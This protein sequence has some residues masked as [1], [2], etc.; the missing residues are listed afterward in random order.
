MVNKSLNGVLQHIRKL[1]AVQ[2][3]RELADHELLQRFVAGKDEAAFTVLVQRHGPMIMGVCRRMLSSAHDAEDACQAS[4]LVL[5]QKAASIRKTT[6]LSSWL[7]GVASRVAANLKRER[8]RRYKRE[9]DSQ[10]RA[11]PDPAAEI[12]WREV[13]AILDEELQRLPERSRAPLILCYLDGRTRDEAAERLGLSVACLHGRLERARKALCERLTRRGVTLSATLVATAIG[14]GVS[15]AALSPT[16]VLSTARAAVLLGSGRALDNTLIST[17]ILCLAQEVARNMFLTKL[18]LGVSALICAGLLVT[19]LD[20]SL[21]WV[22][23]GQ[24]R[25]PPTAD[26]SP[27]APENV[28]RAAAPQ[29]ETKGQ[30]PTV[31]IG[32]RVLG[33]LG[34][35]VKGAKIY[36]PKDWGTP[37]E[38]A[39]SDAEG[40]FRVTLP[41][42]RPA[43]G[44]LIAAA[45]G[46]GVAWAD[47]SDVKPEAEVTLRL[48]ED[49]PISGRIRDDRGRPVAAARVT[50]V[51][52]MANQDK[53][54]E[55]LL[56]AM[57]RGGSSSMRNFNRRAYFSPKPGLL[58]TTRTDSDGRFALSRAGRD[59]VAVLLVSGQDIA[60]ARLHVVARAGLDLDRINKAAEESVGPEFRSELLRLRPPALDYVAGPAQT[61]DGVVREHGTG[62]P[63]AEASVFCSSQGWAGGEAIKTDGQ[64]RFHLTGLAKQKEYLVQAVKEAEG[65]A[66]MRRAIKLEDRPGRDPLKA[67][68]E[69]IR[70]V[71]LAGQVKDMATEKGVDSFVSYAPLPENKFADQPGFDYYLM[72]QVQVGFEAPGGRFRLVVI[73]GPGVLMVNARGEQAPGSAD[74]VI[75]YRPAEIS[76]KDSKKVPL[77]GTAGPHPNP[78]FYTAGTNVQSVWAH[79][80]LKLFDLALDAKPTNCEIL[81]DPGKTLEVV[82]EDGDGKPVPGAAVLGLDAE[83]G[84]RHKV[85]MLPEAR[86]SVRALDPKEPRQLIFYHAGRKIAGKVTIKG[87]ETVP[88]VKLL[89]LGSVTGRIVDPGGK[90]VVGARVGLGYDD[91]GANNLV[92][93]LVGVVGAEG[94]ADKDGRFRIEGVIPGLKFDLD[95]PDSRSVL[96]QDRRLKGGEALE[97][98]ELKLKKAD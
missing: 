24:A 50:V 64:G 82:V 6:S 75:P 62:K 5:A 47:A 71:V 42:Q 57:E 97:L 66:W 20:G 59:R 78:F 15:R 94:K 93:R 33:P 83:A 39:E 17:K 61:I 1:A 96:V 46:H 27:K 85:A 88:V 14:E 98:G 32:G 92:R 87:D 40:R 89:P 11:V 84:V 53:P 67:E 36:F 60:P 65:E 48:V 51:E 34:K 7:H 79:N 56:G 38:I 76:A 12:S 90:P 2:S 63:I 72:P 41:A 91:P 31:V 13:Q 23:A 37:V 28:K 9:K 10:P 21:A 16:L 58:L 54:L 95:T 81:L 44:Q 8:V 55:E 74:N 86:C 70:G 68:V 73:P 80:A 22:G 49:E 29:N 26:P 30:V 4:F 52:L 3:A 19:A 18:K 35:P 45:D 77:L 69:M 43:W 25:V